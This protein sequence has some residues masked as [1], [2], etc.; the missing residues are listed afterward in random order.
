MNSHEAAELRYD[1]MQTSLRAPEQAAVERK[2]MEVCPAIRAT[3]CGVGTGARTLQYKDIG[4]PRYIGRPVCVGSAGFY[5]VRRATAASTLRLDPSGYGGLNARRPEVSSAEREN[6]RRHA[7]RNHRDFAGLPLTVQRTVLPNPSLK[8]TPDS[9]AFWP[10]TGC[11]AHFPVRGQ[12]AMPS[13][14]A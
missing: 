4:S 8:R 1:I 2:P 12:N 11:R 6:V 3:K 7:R 5:S 14:A 10:R 9:I 13:A